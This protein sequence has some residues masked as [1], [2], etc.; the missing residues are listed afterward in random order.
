MAKAVYDREPHFWEDGA[1][2]VADTFRRPFPLLIDLR[3]T[4]EG[5]RLHSVQNLEALECDED[6]IPLG[7]QP[8]HGPG[9]FL[10]WVK[11]YNEGSI[12]DGL[13]E[14]IEFL[15]GV[16]RLMT[17]AEMAGKLFPCPGEPFRDYAARADAFPAPGAQVAA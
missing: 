15:Y 2:I 9:E 4:E 6:R 12:F 3:R 1:R 5:I 14:A 7:I 13:A 16:G 10:F 8:D 17:P 11:G